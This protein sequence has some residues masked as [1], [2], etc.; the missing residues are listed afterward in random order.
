MNNREIL[1]KEMADLKAKEAKIRAKR[2]QIRQKEM[3]SLAKLYCKKG[4]VAK[5]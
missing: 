5:F 1:A 3:I 4:S 2:K